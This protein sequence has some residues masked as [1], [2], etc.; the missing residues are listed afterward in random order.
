MSVIFAFGAGWSFA[1]PY[2]AFWTLASI[3]GLL[4]I[5]RPACACGSTTRSHPVAHA[6]SA[7]IGGPGA[8][9]HLLSGRMTSQTPVVASALPSF[10]A[11]WSAAWSRSFWSAYFSAKSAIAWSNLPEPPR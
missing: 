9:P 7:D 5:F 1:Q 8:W 2:N 3:L 6:T 10:T 11:A 4:L